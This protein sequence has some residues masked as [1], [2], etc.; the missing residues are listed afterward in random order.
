MD[1]RHAT[2]ADADVIAR[3]HVTAWRHAYRGILPDTLIDNLSAQRRAE[4]WRA[5]IADDRTPVCV[6]VVDSDVVGFAAIGMSTDDDAEPDL[7]ELQS[8][9]VHPAS[10]GTGVGTALEADARRLLAAQGC[11][12]ATLWV[13]EANETARAFYEAHGWLLDGRR[14]TE[15]FGGPDEVAEVEEVR[16]RTALSAA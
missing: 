9:Y 15:E 11:S 12:E 2:L 8:L 4:D 1:L 3:I 10:A 5:L 7:G 16:Y 6:A 14:R 13:L